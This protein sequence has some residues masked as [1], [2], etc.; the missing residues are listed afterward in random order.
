MNPS[1]LADKY[2]D[3]IKGIRQQSK[4]FHI[5]SLARKMNRMHRDQISM[6]EIIKDSNLPSRIRNHIDIKEFWN[7]FEKIKMEF[8][9]YD[10][11]FFRSDTSL[12]HLLLH[13]GYDCVKP[14]IQYKQRYPAICCR[15]VTVNI[16]RPERCQ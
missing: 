11:P 13:M 3:E 6:I 14:E 4:L 8:V 1:D 9:K 10:I 7:S 2:W 5:V 16:W 15:S 12:L